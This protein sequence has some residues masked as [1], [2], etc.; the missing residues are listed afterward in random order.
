MNGQYI[1]IG[2]FNP[3]GG[4]YVSSF[5]GTIGQ[6]LIYNRALSATEI[7]QNFNEMRSQYGV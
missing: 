2:A 4:A 1:N 5:P 7:T 3:S 6:A